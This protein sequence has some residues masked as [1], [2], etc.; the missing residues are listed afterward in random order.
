MLR[1]S[2]LIHKLIE[3]AGRT[4]IAPGS[5]TVIGIGPEIPSLVLPILKNCTPIN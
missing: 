5:K 2:K 1:E 3:D 4:Q